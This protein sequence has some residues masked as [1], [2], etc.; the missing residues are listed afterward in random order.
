MYNVMLV[1]DDYPVLELL[2][3]SIDWEARGFRLI[4]AFENGAVAWDHAQ[5]EMPDILI[6][7]IGMPKMNGLELCAKIKERKPDARIVILSCHNEF[8]YA[9]QAMRL[10]VQEYLLKETLQPGELVP[11]LER[12]KEDL[13]ADRQMSGERLRLHALANDARELRKEQ[14]FKNF[15]HQP[16]L[17]ADEWMTEANGF[18]LFAEETWCLPAIGY[19]EDYTRAK[20]RF[21][22][23]Q[24]LRFAIANVIAE[25]LAEPEL[26]ALH[27]AYSE[28][29]H[30][31]LISYKPSLKTNAYDRAAEL[32]RIVQKAIGSVLKIRMAFVL[33]TECGATK[34]LKRNLHELVT[35]E[36]QR[37]YLE[38]GAVAKQRTEELSEEDLFVHYD[39][40][41]SELREALI[42][43]RHSDA[44]RMADAWIERI[45]R[46][47]YPPAAV[48]DWALKLVL[49]LK[50]K[51]RTLQYVR[52]GYS[53]DTLHKEISAID[54]VR[55]LREWLSGQ[56][57]ASEEGDRAASINKRPEV[58]E[59]C[60]YVSL[61]LHR[62]ISLD[63]VADSLHLNAS[64]FSRMFKKVTGETFIEYVT[65]MKMD[66]AKELLDQ[67]SHTVGE[68][69]EMLGYD[70]QSYFI[71]TFK[72]HASVTPMEY[73]K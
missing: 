4:G 6:T 46:G 5:S 9:Q 26:R 58:K 40:A 36:E 71:K 23:E 30:L 31:L 16:L 68:I 37:F 27:I 14:A 43:G 67:T 48:K 73:R 63:E 2:S 17:S 55:E 39:A 19:V 61:N 11:M 66:R 33:G 70:N 62:R 44:C 50:L 18:G 57:A 51:L 7:D 49:D 12:F 29:K 64:Y 38:S 72:S 52:S 60:K 22:S 21:A 35:D 10:S 34:A 28:R 45:I 24:T 53:A 42:D 32:C 59:A 15:I 41:N 65:R 8:A 69:S 20:Q 3:E 1:D 25:V 54:S 56:L 13:D 47:R